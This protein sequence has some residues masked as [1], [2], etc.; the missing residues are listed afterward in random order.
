M[1]PILSAPTTDLDHVC[2]T[3]HCGQPLGKEHS[4]VLFF[5][6]LAVILM[7]KKASSVVKVQFGRDRSE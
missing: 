7:Q 3:V 1:A 2:N 4:S 5:A 6:H